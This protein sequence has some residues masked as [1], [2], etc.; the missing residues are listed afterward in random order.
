VEEV[1]SFQ[2][3]GGWKG[4]YGE[5]VGGLECR[6]IGAKKNTDEIDP[7]TAAWTTSSFSLGNS[8]VDRFSIA[9]QLIAGTTS[10]PC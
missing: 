7:S 8:F 10:T 2:C 5:P 3:L 1:F 6:L 4:E 9:A